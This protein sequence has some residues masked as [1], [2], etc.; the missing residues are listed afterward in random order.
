MKDWPEGNKT[1]S[2]EDLTRPVIRAMRF[3][4]SM[5]RRNEDKDIPWAGPALGRD[6]RATCLPYDTALSAANLRYSKE[7]QGRD[8]LTEIVGVAVQLGIEQGRRIAADST[9]ARVND[10]IITTI[11]LMATR[12]GGD[13][14]RLRERLARI[15]E[16]CGMLE[17]A[18]ASEED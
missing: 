7:E 5:K 13:E 12:E 16:L 9:E 2:F 8:A 11:K 14:G 3:A 15:A 17:T 1:A 4:Y 6:M 18:Q 10:M